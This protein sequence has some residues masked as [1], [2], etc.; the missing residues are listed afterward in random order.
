[1]CLGESINIYSLIS[2]SLII[3]W[4]YETVK[5]FNQANYVIKILISKTFNVCVKS[6]EKVCRFRRLMTA[7]K[8]FHKTFG[9]SPH[10]SKSMP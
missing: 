8:V 4:L 5:E 2:D 7:A 6:L 3:V 1:M 10:I 9:I